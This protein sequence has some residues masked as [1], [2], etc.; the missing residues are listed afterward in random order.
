LSAVENAPISWRR[1]RE[2]FAA[3]LERLRRALAAEFGVDPVLL[4]LHPSAVCLLLHR[5]AHHAWQRGHRKTARILAQAGTLATG[6]DFHPASDIGPG[7]FVPHPTGIALMCR[8]GH[9][10]TVMSRSGTGMLPRARDVGAGPGLP[11]LGDDCTLG[12]CCGIEGP[13][14]IGHRVRL[15][16]GIP[17]MQDAPDDTDVG[18]ARPARPGAAPAPRA[19]HPA[20]DRGCRHASWRETRADLLADLDAHL[21]EGRGRTGPQGWQ[22]RLS[23]LL[24][25]QSATLGLH[26]LAHGLHATGRPRLARAVAGLN[27]RLSRADIHPASCVGG[28]WYL[29]HPAGVLFNATAGRDLVMFAYTIVA[30][31]GD[32]LRESP[33][34]G[35]VLGDGVV[36]AAHSAILGP[37]RIGSNVRLG[38]CA[39]VHDDVAEDRLVVTPGCRPAFSA[40]AAP[41]ERAAP[42]PPARD[43]SFTPSARRADWQRLVAWAQPG[44]AL[45]RLALRLSPAWCSVRLYRASRRAWVLGR[46]RQAQLLWQLNMALTG[47]DLRPASRIGPGLLVPYPACVSIH[48]NAGR[49]LTVLA[50]AGIDP[51]PGEAELGAP[52]AAPAEIGDGVTVGHHAGILGPVHVASR[53]LLAA[54]ARVQDDV[55]EGA[56]IVPAGSRAQ[57]QP[58]TTGPLSV[59]AIS[60]PEAAPGG[61]TDARRSG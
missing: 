27:R 60:V 13:Q 57:R 49:D 11:V 24:T 54:G 1:T 38:F 55:P 44:G 39:H 42:P 43:E 53:A 32:A 16:T 40:R 15:L 9:N 18:A 61:T 14:R 51:L 33:A 41:V 52:P 29:P 28:G 37:A 50:M 23:A 45:G 35:P 56:T 6:G 3:D 58:R 31:P 7:L 36:L 46:R 20:T 19:R 12:P 59:E 10:L 25:T 48:G 47:A 5:L 8:A 21:R 4:R 34:S 22:G 26:R 2:R 30:S 17:L